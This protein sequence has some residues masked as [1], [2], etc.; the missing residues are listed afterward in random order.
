MPNRRNDWNT[1]RLNVWFHVRFP[2]GFCASYQELR[3]A[4]PLLVQAAGDILHALLHM[5]CNLWKKSLV[6]PV[7][8]SET[9][10]WRFQVYNMKVNVEPFSKHD[11]QGAEGTPSF[12]VWSIYTQR[13]SSKHTVCLQCWCLVEN[14]SR[15]NVTRKWWH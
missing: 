15:K 9:L 4:S 11:E 2:F 6:K 7:S 12:I 3:V 1:D 13:T 10:A 8:L 5:H 14:S